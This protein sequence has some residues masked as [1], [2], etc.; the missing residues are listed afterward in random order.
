VQSTGRSY[1]AEQPEIGRTREE[2]DEA[3]AYH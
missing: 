3:R 1:V 2:K